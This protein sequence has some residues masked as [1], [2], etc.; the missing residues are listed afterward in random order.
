MHIQVKKYFKKIS[1]KQEQNS[2]K[3][4]KVAICEKQD[5]LCGN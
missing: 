2:L 3:N 5:K 4:Q 1:F